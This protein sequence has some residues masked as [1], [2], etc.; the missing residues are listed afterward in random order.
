MALNSRKRGTLLLAAGLAGLAAT[1]AWSRPSGADT[2]GSNFEAIAAADGVRFT[3]TV[4]NFA[5]VDDIIDGG[6][7]SAQTRFDSLGVS[8]AFASSPYPGETF[9]S[10]PGLVAGFTGLPALP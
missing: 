10:L 6:G 1:G 2:G 3:W 9:V 4:P 5:P 8:T 7:P